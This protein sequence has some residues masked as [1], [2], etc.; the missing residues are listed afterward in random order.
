VSDLG[1]DATHGDRFV[2]ALDRALSEA[3]ATQAAL[4]DVVALFEAL[5]HARLEGRTL[6]ELVASHIGPAKAGRERASEAIAAYERAVM[7]FRAEGMRTL[8]DDEGF[9][10]TAVADQLGVS[11]Q[12]VSRLYTHARADSAIHE[13][14]E[15]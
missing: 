5:R 2:A 11:R 6:G 13:E 4:A 8:I 1:D 10:I 12:L 7:E 9:S 3:A 15:E 14:S